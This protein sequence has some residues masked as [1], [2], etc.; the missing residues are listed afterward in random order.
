MSFYNF[1]SLIIKTCKTIKAVHL[2]LEM[3]KYLH[4]KRINGQ[5]IDMMTFLDQCINYLTYVD[6][7]YYYILF[8]S[9]L[10]FP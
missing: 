6:L 4:T 3:N 10:H 7:Y 2:Q 1:E 9:L 8:I 5:L